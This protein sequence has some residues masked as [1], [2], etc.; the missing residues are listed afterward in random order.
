MVREGRGEAP[1]L[2]VAVEL[3]PGIAAD[4]EKERRMADSILAQLLR[5]NSEF[6]N[7]TPAEYRRPVVELMP[8]GDPGWFPVGVKH[9]YSRR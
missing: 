1:A 9:R 7:Y 5:L 2:Y 4:P 6:A 8:A 3:A